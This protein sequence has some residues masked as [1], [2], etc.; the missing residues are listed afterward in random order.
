MNDECRHTSGKLL[1]FHYLSFKAI[2]H[3]RMTLATLLVICLC[4]M[5]KPCNSFQRTNIFIHLKKKCLKRPGNCRLENSQTS[6]WNVPRENK[7]LFCYL[8]EGYSLK[9]K[10]KK[11][12]LPICFPV[13][14]LIIKT[15][16][17]WQSRT[18]N[19]RIVSQ[20]T[21][22]LVFILFLFSSSLHLRKLSI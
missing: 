18:G 22:L 7:M 4:C 1:F 12:A 3:L 20:N 9:L 2:K 8:P 21:K 14:F 11:K 13:W 10:K 16:T 19:R 17:K 5:L 15:P 6:A